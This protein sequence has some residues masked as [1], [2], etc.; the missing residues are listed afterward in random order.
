MNRIKNAAAASQL[1][2]RLYLSSLSCAV[3]SLG[4]AGAGKETLRAVSKVGPRGS[5]DQRQLQHAATQ[6]GPA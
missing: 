3:S 4:K 5:W 6:T 1:E 2:R